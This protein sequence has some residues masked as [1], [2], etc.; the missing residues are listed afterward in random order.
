MGTAIRSMG[1]GGDHDHHHEHLVFEP[2]Y[3]PLVIGGWL[4]FVV[5][6]DLVVWYGHFVTSSGNKDF[7]NRYHIFIHT[8]MIVC[9]VVLVCMQMSLEFFVAVVDTYLQLCLYFDSL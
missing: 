7:G 5:A 8:F 4:V 1:G 3:N 2:P 9:F 6:V